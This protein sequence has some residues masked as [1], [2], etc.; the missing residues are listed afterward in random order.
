MGRKV[1]VLE[2]DEQ[3]RTLIIPLLE[4][5]EFEVT[6]ETNGQTALDKIAESAPDLVMVG[7]ALDDIDGIGFII[8]LRQK[9]K[10]IK[11]VFLSQ[12]WRDA[13]FF[14]KVTKELKVA[15]IFHRPIKSSVFGV[16]VDALWHDQKRG[17]PHIEAQNQEPI[18]APMGTVPQPVPAVPGTGNTPWPA[19]GTPQNYNMPGLQN[20][21]TAPGAQQMPHPEQMR[22][23]GQFQRPAVMAPGGPGPGPGG[24]GPDRQTGAHPMPGGPRP[25]MN[26]K[27][28]SFQMPPGGGPPIP[29]GP[30][31]PGGPPMPGAPM[32]PPNR[33]TGNYQMP[34]PGGPPIPGQPMPGQIF[35]GQQIQYLGGP[36]PVPGAPPMPTPQSVNAF[37]D[38]TLQNF[39][40]RFSKSLP[41]RIKQIEE[42]IQ[43][44]DRAN[45]DGALLIEIRRLSHNLKGTSKSCGFDVLGG[46][47]EQIECS[48]RDMME[49]AEVNHEKEWLNIDHSML[50]AK[51]EV[52]VIKMQFSDY[53]PTAEEIANMNPNAAKA[54][55]LVV[56]GSEL[57]IFKEL[58]TKNGGGIP[59]EIISTEAGEALERAGKQELDAALIEITEHNRDSA[60]QLARELRSMIG[61]ETLPLGFIA[62]NDEGDRAEAAHAGASLF[63]EKPFEKETLQQALQHLI[64]IREGGRSRVLIVDDD[65]DFT[66]LISSTLGNEGMLVKALNDPA[67]VLDIL[68]EFT[69]DLMLL[70]V[71]M[72]GIL[73]FDVCKKVRAAGRWQELPIIFLTAQTDLASRLNA[74]DSGGDDY[75]PKPV[76][77]VELLR[78]VKVRLERARMARE[79]QD[80][81]LLTGLLLR[82][83]FAD[84]IEALVSESERHG[85]NFSLCL[86]DVDHFKKVNDTYGHMAG[87]KVLAY[88]GKLLRKRFRV[89]DLRGRWG[90][91]EFILAFR[92]ERKETM[93]KALDRVLEELKKVEFKGD[94]GEPFFTSFSAGMV[95]FPEDGTSLHDLVLNADRRLYLAKHNGR[96]QIVI[97]G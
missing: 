82:R 59:L 29:G 92:H 38:A 31:G 77:N 18:P 52:D 66:D 91:E 47:A 33:Q 45:I 76:I 57:D 54:K 20:Q 93:H 68:E 42:L 14:Q 5:R 85:F 10:E 64:T 25:P 41:S 6:Q 73:G 71:M 26:R 43:K 74:F 67:H 50:A 4:A 63:L 96:S 53:V 1:L 56:G 22:H 3:L 40:Q 34:V 70:D 16:Q 65:P 78:R 94:K 39:R 79:R 83:A 24:P 84:Q 46:Y 35:Q 75:L 2:T 11:V 32:G 21:G 17:L 48:A 61:Y 90:G 27:T 30:Q 12:T 58:G 81:D 13:E 69:P 28:G 80:R 51:K 23:T 55:V 88:F 8:K 36:L 15:H 87:D 95:D 60:F 97:T 9:E 7:E 37:A 86:M 72:P 62:K 44:V 89:E 49:V 19:P